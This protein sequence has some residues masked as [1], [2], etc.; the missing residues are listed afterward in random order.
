M[1]LRSIREL[2]GMALRAAEILWLGLMSTSLA[3]F[4]YDMAVDPACRSAVCDYGLAFPL[5]IG[6][7]PLYALVRAIVWL[8]RWVSH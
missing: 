2:L 8:A 7:M 5:L 3:V 6:F 4:G 1:S